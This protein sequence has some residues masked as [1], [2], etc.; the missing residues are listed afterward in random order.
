MPARD[1]HSVNAE[2]G[3]IQVYPF[4]S[5]FSLKTNK[6]K[7]QAVQAGKP[8][9]NEKEWQ[10][11]EFKN[12]PSPSYI[13]RT[14]PGDQSTHGNLQRAVEAKGPLWEGRTREV[15]LNYED[16][17]KNATTSGK[18]VRQFTTGKGLSS[19][20]FHRSEVG[21][22]SE[23]RDDRS[24]WQRRHQGFF[25]GKIIKIFIF[26]PGRLGLFSLQLKAS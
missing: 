4:L 6:Q 7:N 15:M 26:K 5:L 16:S 25:L 8:R 1:R 19:G 20:T 23:H 21:H 22:C 10:H 9:R 18:P 12:R 3:V 14:N 11:F 13:H 24:E 2:R 17:F